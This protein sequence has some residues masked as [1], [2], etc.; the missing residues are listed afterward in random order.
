MDD[1]YRR[2][3]NMSIKDNLE[4]IKNRG[5]GKFI[6]EQYEKYRCVTCGSLISVHNRKCFK[7]DTITKLVVKSEEKKTRNR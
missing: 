7:C 1:R 5:I 4:Y 2:N 3:Y 6:E